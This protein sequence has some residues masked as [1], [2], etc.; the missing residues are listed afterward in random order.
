M[1]SDQVQAHLLYLPP[2][3]TIRHY[4]VSYGNS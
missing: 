2:F 4:L 3:V 1:K